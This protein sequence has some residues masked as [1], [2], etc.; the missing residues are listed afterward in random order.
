MQAVMA[1]SPQMLEWQYKTL[2][3][4]LQQ[5]QLHAA[6]PSCPCTWAES[7]EHCLPKHSLNVVSLAEETAAMDPPNAALLYE[8]QESATEMHQI[9]KAGDCGEGE[10]TDVVTWSREWR[11]KIEP[12][13][14][15]CTMQ[16][17]AITCSK[18]DV[19]STPICE[20]KTE[21]LEQ[22][23]LERKRTLKD[24]LEVRLRSLQSYKDW[25]S[26]WADRPEKEMLG[27]MDEVENTLMVIEHSPTIARMKQA[28]PVLKEIAS[29]VCGAGLCSTDSELPI[30]TPAER[31]KL[32]SCV[33]KVQKKNVKAGC[34]PGGEGT[35]ECPV[36][37][38][39]CYT[40]IGCRPATRG[41]ARLD[42]TEQ[43]LEQP[44]ERLLEV[45]HA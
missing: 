2:L 8:L 40:A 1:A 41:R 5:M 25:T 16:Q 32:R 39:V 14:Y 42:T 31:K 22:A 30:C 7:G 43:P 37:Y 12:I 28:D 19:M 21:E 4:E 23:D 45:C 9:L 27:R 11:K 33:R 35:A 13:Y 6:D 29:Q 36:P 3:K 20:L 34:R 17:P 15:S 26:M 10:D 24:Y 18:E 38:A 44:P